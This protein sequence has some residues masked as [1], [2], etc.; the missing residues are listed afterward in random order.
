MLQTGR[1]ARYQVE[2]TYAVPKDYSNI[3]NYYNKYLNLQSIL[4]AQSDVRMSSQHGGY[5]IIFCNYFIQSFVLKLSLAL[6]EIQVN[7]FL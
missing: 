1:K 2:V 5:N 3:K 7:I 6:D 4:Q